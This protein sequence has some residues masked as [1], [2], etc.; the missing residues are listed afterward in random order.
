MQNS[1]YQIG[2]CKPCN[3]NSFGSLTD[4]C[5]QLTGQCY[6]VDGDVTGRDCSECQVQ[7]IEI[8]IVWDRYIS[9]PYERNIPIYN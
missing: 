6:C 3:C 8:F 5:D 2:G 1:Q 4:Q 7:Y 9:H